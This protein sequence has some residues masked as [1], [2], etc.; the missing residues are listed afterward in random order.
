MEAMLSYLVHEKM[1]VIR[2]EAISEQIYFGL[3][4]W[5]FSFF[6]IFLRFITEVALQEI[7]KNPI[8]FIV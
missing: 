5:V 1:E 3:K 6:V 7:Q 2:H 4:P 8:I